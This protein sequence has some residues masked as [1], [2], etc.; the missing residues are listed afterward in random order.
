MLLVMDQHSSHKARLVRDYIDSMNVRTLIT[1][2]YSSPMNACEHV[3]S[4]FKHFFAKEMS[5]ITYKYNCSVIE[6]D[7]E[8]IIG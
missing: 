2:P 1:P 7:M 5:K 8:L 6:R 3:W 4:T